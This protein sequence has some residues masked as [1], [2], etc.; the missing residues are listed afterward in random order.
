ME[1]H[2][3]E[4]TIIGCLLIYFF[5]SF[6]GW[7]RSHNNGIAIFIL[8]LLLGWTILGWVCALIWSFTNSN[9][10]AQVVAQKPAQQNSQYSELEKLASLKEKGIIT[11]EEFNEKKKQILGL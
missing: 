7:S 6:I 9:K 11:E 4:L 8:N 2:S 5:P 3:I 10:P 1:S